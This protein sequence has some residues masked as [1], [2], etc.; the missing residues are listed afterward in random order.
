MGHL[1]LATICTVHSY[2]V[3]KRFLGNP[4]SAS[5]PIPKV[6]ATDQRQ[7]LADFTNSCA[8]SHI[9]QG[10]NTSHQTKSPIRSYGYF[11]EHCRCQITACPTKSPIACVEK[12]TSSSV[13]TA[14]EVAILE[15]WLSK[16][17]QK[18]AG[19]GHS[20]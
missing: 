14:V 16:P 2:M 3:I 6:D 5:L 9:S 17:C 7:T 19:E 13:C 11:A 10:S 12:H 1:N 15:D 20:V 18:S 8:Y 4:C